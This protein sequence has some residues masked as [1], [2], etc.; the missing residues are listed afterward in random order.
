M[1]FRVNPIVVKYKLNAHHKYTTAKT[2][3]EIIK[4]NITLVMIVMMLSSFMSQLI[5]K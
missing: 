3:A 4:L 1:D 2:N 5:T